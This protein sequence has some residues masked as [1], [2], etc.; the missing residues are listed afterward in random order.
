MGNIPARIWRMRHRPFYLS[1]D[2]SELPDW[3]RSIIVPH[4]LHRD[5]AGPPGQ[6]IFSGD[7]SPAWPDR[8][9]RKNVAPLCTESN[10]DAVYSVF[11]DPLTYKWG[12]VSADPN[13]IFEKI[14]SL[15]SG[16]LAAEFL[17]GFP[18]N[19]PHLEV[20]TEF[21]KSGVEKSAFFESPSTYKW[22]RILTKLTQENSRNLKKPLT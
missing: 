10:W 20:G 22:G 15:I 19:S 7:R 11:K 1:E 17:T 9:G 5:L 18:K 6:F 13:R 4:R 14:L 3:D 12:R 16:G 8:G 21:G 2:R